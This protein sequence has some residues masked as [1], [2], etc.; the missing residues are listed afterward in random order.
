MGPLIATHAGLRG[1]PGIDLTSEVVAG[2]VGGLAALLDDR[3]LAA[4]IVVARD[5]RP[6]GSAL[7]GQ[8]REAA[9]AAGLDVVDVGVASTPAAKRFL[10]R[11]ELGGAVIVTGSHLAPELN[12]LKLVAG[13]PPCPV[14]PRDLPAAGAAARPG[15]LRSHPG[16]GRAHVAD[17]AAGVDAAAI[18][19]ARL[20]AT[21]QGGVGD[22]GAALLA[23]L[24]V[25]HGDGPRFV[26]DADADR[27][28]IDGL[29]SD[30]VLVLAATARHPAIL[31]RGADSTRTVAAHA[32]ETVTVAPGELHL[33]EAMSRTGAELAGEG[34]GGVVRAE[35]ASGRDG[36]AT[37]ALILELLARDPG[38][39][40]S[41]RRS[42]SAAPPSRS[43]TC[44]NAPP[45]YLMP[46][47]SAR[48]EASSSS[49]AAARGRSCER[50]P[51]SLSPASR[52]RPPARPA[53]QPCSTT[54]SRS[55][56]R[57]RLGDRRA[58]VLGGGRGLGA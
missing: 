16:A 12:G 52:P 11:H 19:A 4:G 43:T 29:A 23:A 53:P 51:P 27:L 42:T 24:G 48:N 18:R 56:A 13:E 40:A 57:E 6:T 22:A 17:I 30:A 33:I 38:V 39:L 44:A 49:A 21:C 5:E 2:A 26:L 36:L 9:L 35:T 8:V 20:S 10:S 7:A 34:N 28:A 31:V 37:M 58:L 47:I 41:L 14:D 46:S 3:G 32:C 15:T 45:A 25:A 54:C 1:R 50:P 55:Y